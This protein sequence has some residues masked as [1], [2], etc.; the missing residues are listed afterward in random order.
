MKCNIC[1]LCLKHT[2][3]VTISYYYEKKYEK[4]LFKEK[5]ET[6]YDSFF[7]IFKPLS[8]GKNVVSLK[9]IFPLKYI[10]V[11]LVPLFVG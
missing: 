2:I 9:K 7:F 5:Q 6:C 10:C 8:F 1:L 3:Y 4:K 11:M